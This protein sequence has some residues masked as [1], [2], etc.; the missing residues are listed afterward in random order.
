MV[1]QGVACVM[2]HTVGVPNPCWE[3][4]YLTVP[5]RLFDK[6]LACLKRMGYRSV[7]LREYMEIVLAGRLAREKVV[8]LTFDDG[9]LDNWVY[10]APLLERH[11][12]KATVFISTDFINPSKE[13]RPQ[14]DLTAHGEIGP[15]STGFLTWDEARALD[16][17]GIIE[18]QSHG[19]TH[20]WY[21][22][23]PRIVDFRHPGDSYYW[24][25]WN[26]E[27]QKKWRYM[28]SFPNQNIW[29]APV[30]E[31]KKSLEAPRF[32]PDERVA[33]LLREHVKCKG[34][35]FFE[36][37][38]WRE[39]LHT[40]A[41]RA[42]QEFNDDYYET[43]VEFMTRVRTEFESSKMLLEANL[44]KK[45]D[46]FCWPGGGYNQEV[47][48]LAAEFY[49][50][51][52]VASRDKFHGAGLDSLGCFR[53]SRIAPPGL[54]GRDGYRYLGP[55]MLALHL[56][57]VRSGNRFARLL[58]GGCK[59]AVEKWENVKCIFGRQNCFTPP[60]K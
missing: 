47:F 37:P 9:Y 4:N 49:V 1:K 34:R 57:E 54:H 30:Y 35:A 45:V 12:F 8:S 14:L 2:L 40:M 22:S 13:L 50:G 39:E 3:W 51:T 52:S 59:V 20:T 23:G 29:G 27:P 7:H 19:L 60:E 43:E 32:H 25:D 48:N 56:E 18:V 38:A 10:A 44:D 21:P 58:R 5:W 42:M 15:P 16:A 24:M 41:R 33:L 53:F 17:S 6:Q 55:W 36:N 46:F 26:A 28:E 31:H 11:G